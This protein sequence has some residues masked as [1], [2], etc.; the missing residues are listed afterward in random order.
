MLS[1]NTLLRDGRY[2]IG[3]AISSGQL[4]AIYTA[5]DQTTKQQVAVIV[6][7]VAKTETDDSRIENLTNL[8]HDGL[9]SI[10]DKF[11]ENGFAFKITEPIKELEI[12]AETEVTLADAEVAEAFAQLSP[13]MLALDALR[14]EFPSLRSIEILPEN[15]I[16]TADGKFK[17]LFIDRPGI[18]FARNPPDSPYLPFERVWNDLDMIAQRAF[19]RE[20][21]DAA[22]AS[23]EAPPDERSDLYSIGAVFYKL[24]TSHS[25]LTAFERALGMLDTKKDA[26]LSLT[27]LNPAVSEA[28]SQFV[29]KVLQLKREDRFSSFD[30]AI[31]SLPSSSQKT[32][33]QVSP[34]P[35]TETADLDLLEIPVEPELDKIEVITNGH[36]DNV[37]VLEELVALSSMEVTPESASHTEEIDSFVQQFYS[38]DQ[39]EE[40]TEP[41]QIVEEAEIEE[42][43][44]FSATAPVVTRD[45]DRAPFSIAAHETPQNSG[46]KKMVATA[47]AGILVVGIGGFVLMS[48]SSSDAADKSDKQTTYQA[49]VASAPEPEPEPQQ[50]P[51]PAAEPGNQTTSAQNTATQVAEPQTEAKQPSAKPRT[52][53]AEVNPKSTGS[54]P[55]PK[56]EQKPKKKITV[57]DLLN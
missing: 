40:K 27:S 8:Q 17:L 52:Q 50:Q 35:A 33:A 43:I 23:V 4:G 41:E 11:Q 26:L 22:L 34:Q 9:V 24:L 2:R 49:P 15:V 14:K 30:E 45:H 54:K 53:V 20:F 47:A 38:Q 39:V 3:H 29:M 55:A 10:T 5:E 56:P 21:D 25:P 18:L 7:T 32:A 36:H 6:S 19:Y 16:A 37:P 42:E 46:L 1:S 44:G 57:D 28:Q 48:F 31:L 51:S 12:F 13:I